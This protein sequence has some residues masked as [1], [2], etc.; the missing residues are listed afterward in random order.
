MTKSVILGLCVLGC[1][2]ASFAAL[3]A[4]GVNNTA[5]QRSILLGVALVCGV[6][7]LAVLSRR[8]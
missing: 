8:G 1:V 7:A 2:M 3:E 6:I 5:V 4:L